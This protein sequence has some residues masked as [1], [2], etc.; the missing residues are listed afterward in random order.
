GPERVGAAGG[1][2]C[3]AGKGHDGAPGVRGGFELAEAVAPGGM[4]PCNARGAGGVPDAAIELG[5]RD[6]EL[7]R[8]DPATGA[9]LRTRGA[10]WSTDLYFDAAEDFLRQRRDPARPFFLWLATNAP[11]DPRHAPPE[12]LQRIDRE[13]LALPPNL[14]PAPTRDTGDLGVRDEQ[15]YP[16]PRDEALHRREL[17]AYLAM[18]AHLDARAGRL[19]A[20]LDELGLREDTLVVFT[21]DHGLSMGEHGLMGKQNLDQ[22]SWR[23]PM[24]LAGPG[25]PPGQ[26]R[27]GL[28]YLHDL[29]PS[30]CELAGVE[31][32]AHAR[33][34]SFARLACGEVR[35]GRARVFGAYTPDARGAAGV[36][37]VRQGRW[38]LVRYLHTGELRLFDLDADPWELHDRSGEPEYALTVLRLEEQL[39]G[40]MDGSGDPQRD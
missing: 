14:A 22:A 19:L 7:I 37:C 3:A 15:V 27:A 8:I 35:G 40:W 26:R 32:P 17:Q 24:A 20:L 33:A 28:V 12:F 21:S 2:A 13:R 34:S 9:R 6:P 4:L 25:L 5:Q 11:H 39:R 16:P 31:A 10:G 18:M 38:K 30:L 23:V 36:R 1:Q 29:G